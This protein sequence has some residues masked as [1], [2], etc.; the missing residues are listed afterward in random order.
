MTNGGKY[1]VIQVYVRATKCKTIEGKDCPFLQYN[2]CGI[3]GTYSCSKYGI[4]I[5]SDTFDAEGMVHERA[6]VCIKGNR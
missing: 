4:S 3:G 6:K 2:G 5:N 1:D